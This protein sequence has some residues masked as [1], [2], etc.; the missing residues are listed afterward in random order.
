MLLWAPY[1]DT[2]INCVPQPLK[3]PPN[4]INGML[5]NHSIDC[6]WE[7]HNYTGGQRGKWVRI[8]ADKHSIECEWKS[9]QDVCAELR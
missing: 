3:H 2:N 8:W 9:C 4:G 7:S 1:M 6:E 5:W